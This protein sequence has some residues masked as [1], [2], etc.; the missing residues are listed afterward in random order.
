[1]TIMEEFEEIKKDTAKL[2][3]MIEGEKYELEEYDECPRCEKE[4][5]PDMSCLE[6]GA[7][8]LNV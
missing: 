1:M 3:K 7:I 6:A 5:S 2:Q 4:H 8:R